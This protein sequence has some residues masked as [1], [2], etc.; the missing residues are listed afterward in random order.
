MSK[1]LE[2]PQKEKKTRG[3]VS[4]EINPDLRQRMKEIAVKNELTESV[5]PRMCLRIGMPMVEKKLEEFGGA[6]LAS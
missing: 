6:A 5:V 4:I 1:T 2:K 3:V